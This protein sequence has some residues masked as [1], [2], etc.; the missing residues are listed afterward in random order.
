FWDPSLPDASGNDERAAIY[1]AM[2]ATLAALHDVD[3]GAIGL[4]DFGRPGSYFVRQLAR[5]AGQYRASETETI[6]DIDRLVAWL[7]THMPVDDG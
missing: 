6:T 4:G 1:D 7:E 5:W 3:V 2:N